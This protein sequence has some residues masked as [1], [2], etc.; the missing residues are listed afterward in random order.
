ME[1]VCEHCGYESS[2]D[3]LLDSVQCPSCGEPV[4]P[5]R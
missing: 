2:T 1:W 5:T 4:T 3:E